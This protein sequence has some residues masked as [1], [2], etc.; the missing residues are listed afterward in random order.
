MADEY[1][2]IWEKLYAG[3][4]VLVIGDG[5]LR[6]RLGYAYKSGITRLKHTVKVPDEFVGRLDELLAAID[7]V[8]D[9]EIGSIEASLKALD[10]QELRQLAEK[11]LNAYDWVCHKRGPKHAH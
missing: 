9:E 11:F 3:V 5:T 4:R 7:L 1:G 6:E 2:Y 8:H 10:E